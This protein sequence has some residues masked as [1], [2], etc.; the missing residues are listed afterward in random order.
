L[1]LGTARDPA[2]EGILRQKCKPVRVSDPQEFSAQLCFALLLSPVV[3]TI[4]GFDAGA[5]P[6]MASV[7]EALALAAEIP[8]RAV[9]FRWM[10][11]GGVS[12]GAEFCAR[13]ETVYC[14]SGRPGEQPE[15]LAWIAAQLAARKDARAAGNGALQ[16]IQARDVVCAALPAPPSAAP[17]NAWLQAPSEALPLPQRTKTARKG[18]TQPKP[19]VAPQ[20]GKALRGSAFRTW[21]TAVLCVAVA[22]FVGCGG[23][24]V[25]YA[26]D[27]LL[28]RRSNAAL[29]QLY[30][31]GQT[32]PGT[33]SYTG[34][35][36]LSKFSALY[37]ANSDLSG[38]LS[39]PGAGVDLPVYRAADNEYYLSHSAEK[40]RSR[41]GALFLDAGNSV[42]PG[43]PSQN[44]SIY[45]HN[46]KN[47]SM[48]GQL[49]KFRDLAFYKKNAVFSFDTL[50]EEKQW[51]VFAVIVTNADPAQDGGN[52][53]EWREANLSNPQ[54]ME[55]F[56]EQLR[57]RSLI[58]S[59][60]EVGSGDRLLSLTT[61]CYDFKDARLVVFARE[62]RR[63]ET[64]ELAAVAENANPLLPL[65]A[66]KE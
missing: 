64:V 38:W 10:Q 35:G 47:G 66:R 56:L 57:K 44:L 16:E 31:G 26:A 30:H 52:F 29:T 45:G 34:A 48:F 1:L 25:H 7:C 42:M 21:T 4:G 53:F 14:V 28:Q 40:A 62:L 17:K 59:P 2:C 33:L 11:E 65:A 3:L 15:V 32:R 43:Q 18:R 9:R 39:I 46:T 50:Y 61:C 23:Y 13:G 22:A 54:S 55:A 12:L 41:Y 36:M 27:G 63:G 37:E 6:G 8:E 51:V 24:L 19:K 5:L 60:V 49:K 20:G 58:E